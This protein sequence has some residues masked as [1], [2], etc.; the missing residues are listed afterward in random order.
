MHILDMIAQV[1]LPLNE[2]GSF[3][4]ATTAIE[5]VVQGRVTNGDIRRAE[6]SPISL[7]SVL[8]V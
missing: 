7:D 5:W 2:E 3:W 4:W 6:R 1:D 8:K